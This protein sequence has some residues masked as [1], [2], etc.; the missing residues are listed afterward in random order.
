MLEDRG[1]FAEEKL[2]QPFITFHGAKDLYM[3]FVINNLNANKIASLI[4]EKAD[5]SKNGG[6]H[7]S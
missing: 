2:C 3:T 7:L 5:S 1:C 4:I 6:N